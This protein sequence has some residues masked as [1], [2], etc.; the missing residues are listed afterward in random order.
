MILS[1]FGCIFGILMISL[2]FG[3]PT[4]DSGIFK[5]LDDEI[6]IFDGRL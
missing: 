1:D 3:I 6:G 5:S 2:G 4:I